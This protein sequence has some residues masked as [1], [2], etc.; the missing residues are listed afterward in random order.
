MDWRAAVQ[1][2][3]KSRT[4]LSDE[5]ACTPIPWRSS[6][7][8]PLADG[9]RFNSLPSEMTNHMNKRMQI[10]EPDFWRSKGKTI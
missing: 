6:A 5:H 8:P 4:R 2:A 1:V 7:W 10:F 9:E 3:T